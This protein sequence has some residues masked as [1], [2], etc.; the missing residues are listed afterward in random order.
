MIITVVLELS[1]GVRG[2][3]EVRLAA[4]R[5]QAVVALGVRE[6][7]VWIKEGDFHPTGH[8]RSGITCDRSIP[9]W[10]DCLEAMGSSLFLQQAA[11]P[12][13]SAAKVTLDRTVSRTL[14]G[15][16]S[17]NLRPIIEGSSIH[18]QTNQN[19]HI[20][21]TIVRQRVCFTSRCVHEP[22][23]P[24]RNTCWKHKMLLG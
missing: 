4:T 19:E 3:K 8:T 16:H 5:D 21:L 23:S 13:T 22:R 14:T 15:K 20:R 11:R 2:S 1:A 12:E 9:P 24:H 17:M 7:V 18:S 6:G 10:H